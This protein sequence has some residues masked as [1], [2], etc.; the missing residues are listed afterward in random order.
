MTTVSKV[1]PSPRICTVPS[2][3][4]FSIRG[5]AVQFHHLGIRPRTTRRKSPA[6]IPLTMSHACSSAFLGAGALTSALGAR[7]A[8]FPPRDQ[9]IAIQG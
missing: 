7:G 5:A 2:A 3:I 9:P 6:T 8:C 1:T 4:I